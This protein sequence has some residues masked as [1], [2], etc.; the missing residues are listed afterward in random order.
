MR[1]WACAGLIGIN[2][3]GVE[4]VFWT[5]RA[6]QEG[7]E[8][9]SR[10]MHALS[11]ELNHSCSAAQELGA[12]PVAPLLTTRSAFEPSLLTTRSAEGHMQ[13]ETSDD[14]RVGIRQA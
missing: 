11:N 3:M 13:P 12:P 14:S 1:Y 9:T 10:H 7:E 2:F 5:F 4:Q 6:E 8:L